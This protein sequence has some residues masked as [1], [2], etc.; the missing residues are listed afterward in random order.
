MSYEGRNVVE[1]AFAFI[2]LVYGF[3]SRHFFFLGPFPFAFCYSA[4]I[5]E[6]TECILLIPECD[7]VS[8][9]TLQNVFGITFLTKRTGH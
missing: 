9:R 2:T 5:V 3:Q 7:S 4:G 1:N 6:S 8:N